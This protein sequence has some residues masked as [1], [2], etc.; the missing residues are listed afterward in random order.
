[1]PEPQQHRIRTASATYTTA[2]GSAG[3]LTHWARE[4]IEPS[5][6]RF[7]GGFVNHCATAGTSVNIFIYLF[8]YCLFAISWVAPVA[9]GG[10]QAKGRIGAV[11]VGLRQSHS[12]AGSEPESATYTTAHS[13][14]GSLTHWARAGIEPAT[15][16]FLVGFVN[17]CA[18]TGT[19]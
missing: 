16:W 1:M 13:N 7:L 15:S 5:S 8:I 3:S 2:H 9:Y 14:A 4:G 10:S 19:P 17:D 11:A 12:N 6:S 18:T